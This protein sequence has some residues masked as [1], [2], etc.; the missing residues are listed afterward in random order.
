MTRVPS[1]DPE[2][3]EYRYGGGFVSVFGL[4]FLLIG[5]SVAVAPILTEGAAGV[6]ALAATL[7]FGLI[8]ALVGGGLVFGRSSLTIDRRR[9]TVTTWWG[10]LGVGPSTVKP[11]GEGGQV[12]VGCE[13]RGSGKSRHT[14]Y[15]VRLEGSV[16]EALEVGAPQDSSEARRQ[17]EEVAKFLGLG[18]ADRSTGVEI[19][20]EAGTLDESVRDRNARLG[21]RIEL[22]ER[23][24]S[25]RSRYAPLGSTHRVEV[26]ASGLTIMHVL[27]I[28]FGG[29]IG[30]IGLGVT[31]GIGSDIDAPRLAVVM[32]AL[33]FGI[34]ALAIAL[35]AVFDARSRHLVEVSPTRLVVERQ[36]LIGSTRNEFPAREVEELEILGPGGRSLPASPALA[37]TPAGSLLTAFL[38]GQ[39]ILVRS[40]KLTVRFGAGLDPDELVWVKGLIE[41][42][43]CS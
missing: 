23:P 5:L 21:R 12:T 38:G 42:G 41:Y 40:D 31:V 1:S 6:P 28:C 4:P 9:K 18:M 11:L 27:Q 2:V 3:L 24:R 37:G 34:P 13:S 30:L 32:P 16:A 22:P 19:V 26:P 36:G 33:M 7:P 10:A 35:P 39:I 43:L 8:F 15:P 29:F 17:A 14:V 20:R 25:A